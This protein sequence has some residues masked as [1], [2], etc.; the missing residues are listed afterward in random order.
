MSEGIRLRVERIIG[1]N[2]VLAVHPQTGKEMMV[3]GKGLGY[4][5]KAGALLAANDPRIEKKFRLDDQ[6][7][8][9]QY[10]RLTETIQPEIQELADRMIRLISAELTPNLNEGILTA[11]PS[12]L[13]F[14][15]YRLQNGMEINNPFLQETKSLLPDEYEVAKQ[16]A[17]MIGEAFQVEVPEDEIGFLTYHVYSAVKHIP[18]KVLVEW[19]N[20]IAQMVQL[21]EQECGLSLPRD[22]SDY[23]RLISHLRFA[24]DRISLNKTER[25]PF[26][27][28][29][30]K[31]YKTEYALALK[32][33]G[34]M[35]RH[36]RT[37]VPEDEVGYIAMH[38]YRLLQHYPAI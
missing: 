33:A 30:K 23:M 32:L 34:L 20:L 22:S 9:K 3:M 11:L 1:N 24:L 4:S 21:V 13:Q 35:E 36:L 26:I 14:A 18:V 16:A 7:Q 2:V 37:S 25:N 5:L 31:Q 6:Q 10:Q 27:R 17:A 38:L 28:G 8:M 12:H 15:V 29:I 19:S